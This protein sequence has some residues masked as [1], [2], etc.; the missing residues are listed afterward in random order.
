MNN[1][2]YEKTIQKLATRGINSPRL[3]ARLLISDV[4]GVSADSVSNATTV[5]R[6]IS[7]KL[8]ENIKKRLEGMPLDK[9][10]GTKG[11]YKYNFKVSE[12]VLSPRPETEI[13]VEEALRIIQKNR[14]KYVLDLGIGSGCILLS[15]LKEL[16]Q[17]NGIG[18]DASDKAINIA[19]ENATELG[20]SERCQLLNRNWFEDD[21]IQ[22]LNQKFDMI[23]SNPPYIKTDEIKNLDVGVK[24]YDPIFALDG[25][26]DGLKDYRQIATL[27]QKL[28]KQEGYM[29]LEIGFNQE[30]DVRQIFEASGLRHISTIVDYAN[31]DRVVVFKKNL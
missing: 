23:V 3:E 14:F 1:S 7:V 20:I 11:F 19:K 18:I 26:K 30:N 17:L 22:G 21:F 2:I 10:L 16:P 27:S 24:K 12:D 6:Y 29:L 15:L 25:G 5:E 4:L 28:L 8:E 9:I 13:L 31:I